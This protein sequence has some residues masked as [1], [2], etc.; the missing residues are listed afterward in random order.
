M[1]A[2]CLTSSGEVIRFSTAKTTPSDVFTP[3]AVEPSC[4]GGASQA[5]RWK[6]QANPS[7]CSAGWRAASLYGSQVPYLDGF[8]C[9]LHLEQPA[10]GTERVHSSIVF[11]PCQKHGCFRVMPVLAPR[12]LQ[13]SHRTQI[14]YQ[15][16]ICDSGS[17]AVG[18]NGPVPNALSDIA[19]DIV[20][21]KKFCN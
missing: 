17:K 8:N 4:T 3:I 13:G 7:N 1:A 20:K 14:R 9:I 10:L 2:D 16:T 12:T 18:L 21:P 6:L 15:C 19:Y 11:G 5:C